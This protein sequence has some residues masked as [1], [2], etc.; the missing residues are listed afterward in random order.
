MRTGDE[1]TQ[2]RETPSDTAHDARAVQTRMHGSHG[3]NAAELEGLRASLSQEERLRAARLP[4]ARDFIAAHGLLRSV[5]AEILRFDAGDIRFCVDALGKPRLA[6]EHNSDVT[7]SL[8]HTRGG[9]AVAA[10]HGRAVGIDMES[11][12]T[13]R[14]FEALAKRYFAPREAEQV[15]TRDGDARKERFLRLWTLKESYL[16]ARGI[17]IRIALDSFSFEVD[18]DERVHFEAPRDDCAVRWDFESFEFHCDSV[19]MP[20]A[21]RFVLAQAAE[22]VDTA[23]D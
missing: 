11:C 20:R 19:D 3:L 1:G 18:D 22:R 23:D 17:G 14:D 4:D 9:V 2:D 7:F 6:P 5:L 21:T 15:L 12:E 10:A 8:S 13:E 16:K